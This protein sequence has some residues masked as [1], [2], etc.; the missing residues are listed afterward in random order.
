MKRAGPLSL[1]VASAVWGASAMAATPSVNGSNVFAQPSIVDLQNDTWTIIS[2]VIKR[3]GVTVGNNYN[4]NMLLEYDEVFY[5][6]NTSND[7]YKWTGSQWLPTGDPRLVSS[8]GARIGIGTAALVDS[9]RHVW[10]LPS[11]GHVYQDGTPADAGSNIIAMLYYDTAVYFED[12]NDVWWEWGG[13]SWSRVTGD[14]AQSG[15]HTVSANGASI[16]VGTGMLVDAVHNQWTLQSNEWAYIN[17]VRAAANAN[18]TLVLYYGGIIY[19]ENTSG[20]WYS[21]GDSKWT[22]VARDPRGQSLVQTASYTSPACPAGNPGCTPAFVNNSSVTFPRVTTKGDA[23][24]V[25]ATV[26]DYGGIHSITVTD[27]QNNTYHELGQGNDKAPGSQSVAQFYTGNIA[28]GADTITVNWSSDNYKGVV[29]VEIGGVKASPLVG[30]AVAVQ[31]GN[32]AS[33]SDNVTAGAIAV[34]TGGAPA[35]MVALTMDTDGGGSDTGGSGYCAVPAGVGFA[36]VMQVWNWTVAGQTA[37]NL[38]TLETKS[39]TGTG[40]AAAAFT[41]TH[42]SDPYVTVSAVFQ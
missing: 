23:V 20:S 18:T 39:L 33:G 3:N 37:C 2:G 7:W 10:A 14:P 9:Q 28:G 26:S 36:P 17:G 16:G 11:D 27:S 4:V 41:T 5:Q 42:L 29:A 12:A 21:W 8:S 19:S 22:Q 35:F 6:R 1:C 34:N 38:A 25:A 30:S 32:L 24:W 13:N 31:D 15:T 40:A